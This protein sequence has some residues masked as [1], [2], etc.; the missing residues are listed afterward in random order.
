VWHAH[1]ICSSFNRTH[2]GL[3]Q[4]ILPYQWVH[5]IH[6]SLGS[7]W[8]YQEQQANVETERDITWMH[9]KVPNTKKTRIPEWFD[10]FRYVGSSLTQCWRR[11]QKRWKCSVQFSV[12]HFQSTKVW[13]KDAPISGNRAPEG[14]TPQFDRYKLFICVTC[15]AIP[16]TFF[17]VCHN[18]WI[19]S[20]IA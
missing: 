13:E 6:L 17:R 1:I 8:L 14:Y 15:D 9:K 19:G 12:N 20:L 16:G 7:V 2:Q 10:V 11:V 4:T 18:P 5:L 3:Q